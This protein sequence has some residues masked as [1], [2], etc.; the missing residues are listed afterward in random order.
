MSDDGAGDE[1]PADASSLA[2][3]DAVAGGEGPG[4]PDPAVP[5][6]EV[7]PDDVELT[8]PPSADRH[9]AAAIAAAV[10]AKLHDEAVAAAAAAAED[11]GAGWEG[12]RWAFA[13]KVELT[14]EQRVRVPTGA[15]TDAWATSGRTDRF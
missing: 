2:G 11:D 8:L 13:G 14:Q 10:G 3:G 9:E 6:G 5:L 4:D 12:R 1:A 7:L 15:P